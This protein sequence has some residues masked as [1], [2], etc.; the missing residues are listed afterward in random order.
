MGIYFA[1]RFLPYYGICIALGILLAGT[2]GYFLLKHRNLNFDMGLL[3]ASY[4]VIGAGV[5]AKLL[6]LFVERTQIDWKNL[7]KPEYLGQLLQGGY[8]FYGGF[9]GAVFCLW[10]GSKIHKL[11]LPAY[12]EACIP[13]IPL[14][15]A[16]GR[17]GCHLAGCC[18]GIVYDGPGHIVYHAPS[19][20]PTDIPL[21]PVQLT[22]ALLNLCIAS[23]LFI[24]IWKRKTTYSGICLYLS[25]YAVVRFVLETFFR[26]DPERGKF[27]I[28]YTSQWISIL[29]LCGVAVFV[30]FQ[31]WRAGRNN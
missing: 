10:L 17:V 23:F 20:A 1:G 31:H 18:Y 14:G 29:M 4:G 22:E 13:C 28:F 27:L 25:L 11:N 5:G 8:V 6:Y 9:I 21:F 19:A 16:L 3:L 30:G 2:A 15:H 26:G 12:L 24:W 7:F